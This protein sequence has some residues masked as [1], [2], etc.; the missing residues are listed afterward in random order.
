VDAGLNKSVIALELATQYV[1]GDASAGDRLCETLGPSLRNA[2]GRF[3]GYDA[4]EVDD[5]VQESLLAI[6]SYL[7]TRGGFE[8]DLVRFAVTVTRNRCRNI[9]VWR[10]RHPETNIEPLSDWLANPQRS[11]LDLLLEAETRQIL[12]AGLDSLSRACRDLLRWFYIDG[13]SIE[14]LRQQIGLET[15]Q[16]VYYRRSI[17][18][19]QLSRFL[20]SWIARGS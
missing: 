3:L 10:S 12:Q 6:L 19:R 9:L 4:A 18:L 1:A 8:G 7:R 16:G 11:P 14:T 20:N 13:R 17:C 2:A 15:V 5:V